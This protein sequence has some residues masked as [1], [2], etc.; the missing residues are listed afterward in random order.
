MLQARMGTQ[1]EE[2][3]GGQEVEE[4]QEGSGMLKAG[5][6]L[7]PNTVQPISRIV[8]EDDD[9]DD[10]EFVMAQQ[11]QAVC[12]NTHAFCMFH[13]SCD[14]LVAFHDLWDKVLELALSALAIR[15]IERVP[16]CRHAN[17]KRLLSRNQLLSAARFWTAWHPKGRC[18]SAAH[19]MPVFGVSSIVVHG[20]QW[21]AC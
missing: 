7:S 2:S 16:C 9:D 5:D 13:F 14:D 20:L 19:R 21:L 6:E 1:S 10:F 17:Q 4:A 12:F 18:V 11:T 8:D 3:G 15:N